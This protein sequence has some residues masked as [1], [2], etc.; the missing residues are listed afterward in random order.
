[1]MR[2]AET[3]FGQSST[4]CHLEWCQKTLAVES[5]DRMSA[6]EQNDVLALYEQVINQLPV[7]LEAAKRIRGIDPAVRAVNPSPSDTEQ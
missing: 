4:S 5:I 2:I 6:D 7:A 3:T 1:M